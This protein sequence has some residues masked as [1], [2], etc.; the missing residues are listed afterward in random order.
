MQGEERQVFQEKSVHIDG[1]G[2]ADADSAI[3]PK[4]QTPSLSVTE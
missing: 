4:P 2:V 1:S 3:R